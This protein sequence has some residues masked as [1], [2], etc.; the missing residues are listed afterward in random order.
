[1]LWLIDGMNVVGSRPDGWWRDRTGAK[2]ALIGQLDN[3]RRA[4]SDEIVVVL[5]GAPIELPEH[6][7]EV[8]FAGGARDAADVEILRRAEACADPAA[9][10]VVTS[11]GALA[12]AVAAAGVEVVSAGS[13]R[14]RLDE[15]SLR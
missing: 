5:D 11:D 7:V 15:E 13:F 8:V 12:R 1:M 9:A 2:R 14:A 4:T 3:F 6:S 10:R